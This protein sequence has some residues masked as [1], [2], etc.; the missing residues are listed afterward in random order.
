L[1]VGRSGEQQTIGAAA[2]TL[3]KMVISRQQQQQMTKK[4]FLI[5]RRPSR[6]KNRH[7]STRC[8]SIAGDWK[9]ELNVRLG[10]NLPW[11]RYDTIGFLSKS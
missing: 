5:R 7:F 6:L 11:F 1:S 4:S 3:K 2:A 10:E 8:N 9:N